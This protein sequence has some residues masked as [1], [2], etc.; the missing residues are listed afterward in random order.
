M[1]E[2]SYAK[3]MRSYKM[4]MILYLLQSD[5]GDNDYQRH[6]LREA[7]HKRCVELVAKFE[8]LFEQAQGSSHNHQA[9]PGGYIDH[10]YDTMNL[11]ID[12]YAVLRGPSRNPLPFELNDAFLVLFLH[13]LEKPWK[14]V[15]TFASKEERLTFKMQMINDYGIVLTPEQ[16]NAIRY[17]EGEGDDYSS[18]R[19]VMNELAAFCH[20]C[21]VASARIFHSSMPRPSK[22]L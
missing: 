18:T 12:L 8:D 13:D 3:R 20:M 16:V 6:K 10:V 19:R 5:H 7:N 4:R 21:D 2:S 1:N 22:G 17:T 9:W 11:S 15:R 14:S